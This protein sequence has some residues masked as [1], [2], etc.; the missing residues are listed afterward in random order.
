LPRNNK[1]R[2]SS[3][4]LLHQRSSLTF[5]LKKKK[6]TVMK[7]M[8][9]MKNQLNI[10]NYQKSTRKKKSTKVKKKKNTRKS[11]LKKPKK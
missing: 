4:N 3:R 9:N 11:Q 5:N 6:S 1:E 10:R 8:K 2:L 7:N